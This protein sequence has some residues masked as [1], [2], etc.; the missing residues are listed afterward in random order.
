MAD[1]FFWGLSTLESSCIWVN[2]GIISENEIPM[3]LSGSDATLSPSL[4]LYP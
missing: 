4:C 2:V 3:T 1:V